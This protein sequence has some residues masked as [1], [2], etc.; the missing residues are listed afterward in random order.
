VQVPRLPLAFPA[1]NVEHRGKNKAKL[2]E[3]I[4]PQM[5]G[6]MHEACVLLLLCKCHASSCWHGRLQ[7]G[8]WEQQQSTQ[9][10]ARSFGVQKF[11]HCCCVCLTDVQFFPSTLKH[12]TPAHL[13]YQA[14]L[15]WPHLSSW[16]PSSGVLSHHPHALPSAEAVYS[17]TQQQQ[18]ADSS[19]SGTW[20]EAFTP[21]SAA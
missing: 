18:T 4:E 10:D 11:Q 8:G 6:H 1:A 5:E 19:T 2:N 15:H 12:I 7:E 14:A 16:A 17:S 21:A 9:N 3:L 20:G 13:Q